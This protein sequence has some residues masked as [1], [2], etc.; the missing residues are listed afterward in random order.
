MVDPQ[1]FSLKALP[2]QSGVLTAFPP[3]SK[4]VRAVQSPATMWKR[5]ENAVQSHKMPCGG[6]DFEHA[7]NKRRGL[8][9]AKVLDRGRCGNAVGVF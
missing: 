9:F 4:K 3:R 8:A 6:V 2:Q 1:R 7:Q 5:C